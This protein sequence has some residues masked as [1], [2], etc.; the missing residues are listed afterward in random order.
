MTEPTALYRLYDTDDRLLYIGITKNLE[1][2]WTGHKYSPTSSAWWPAVHRKVIEWHPTREAADEAETAAIV[3]EV[4]LHNKD[5]TPSSWNVKRTK[6]SAELDWTIALKEPYSQQ[7][8]RILA[9]ELE[10]GSV[11]PGEPVPTI[12][13]LHQRFGLS[14]A[15]CGVILQTLAARGLV[16]Q[17]G[18]GGR[19]YRSRPGSVVQLP[20]QRRPRKPSPQEAAAL[21]RAVA[22][23]GIEVEVV[24]GRTRSNRRARS[25]LGAHLQ[26]R[27]YSPDPALREPHVNVEL[28]PKEVIELDA[29]GLARFIDQLEAQCEAL[30]EIH[31]RLLAAQ[32][33][34]A[35]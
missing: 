23:D 6:R 2:R 1:Q 18:K 32:D 15:T 10:A 8:A 35:A 20:A 13:D 24:E 17:R 4:P 29:E 30:R 27:P 5:K 25:V 26:I 28:S 34:R 12:K 31:G 33:D 14:A 21:V 22:V 7:A 11:Q 9:A 3:S 16:H 19:Y